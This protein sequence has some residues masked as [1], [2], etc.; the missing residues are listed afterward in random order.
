LLQHF[1]SDIDG[2]FPWIGGNQIVDIAPRL[3]PHVAQEVGRYGLIFGHL[4]FAVM[5]PQFGSD[6]GVKLK[7]K[8]FDGLPQALDIF[9]EGV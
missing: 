8:R 3:G 9:L 7:V 2:S 6:V 1:R 5:G 4:V